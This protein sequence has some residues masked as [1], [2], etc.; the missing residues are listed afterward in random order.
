MD[1]KGWELR[2]IGKPIPGTNRVQ[3]TDLD[4]GVPNLSEDELEANAVRCRVFFAQD[5]DNYLP[6]VV[7]VLRQSV[8]SERNAELARLKSLVNGRVKDGKLIG[9]H[10]YSGRLEADNGLGPGQLLGNDQIAMDYLYGR[11]LHEDDDALARLANVTTDR[12]VRH[13]IV[14]KLHDLMQAV[15]W[16]RW[17]I[18]RAAA[19]GELDFDLN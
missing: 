17:E 14:S 16:T 9:A 6:K 11:L 10:M 8:G 2:F 3:I 18:R 15:Y 13:A 19:D 5:E 12:T 4:F 7:N 1:A